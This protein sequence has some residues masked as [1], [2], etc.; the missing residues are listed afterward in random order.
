VPANNSTNTVITVSPLA[1]LIVGAGAAL[2]TESFD[3]ANNAI[4]P[5]ETVTLNLGLRNVGTADANDLTATLLTTGGVTSPGAPQNYGT[6][7]ANGSA[8]A[9]RRATR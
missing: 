5:G 4:E 1:P 9:V 3:L 7:V 2:T 8:A 6:L